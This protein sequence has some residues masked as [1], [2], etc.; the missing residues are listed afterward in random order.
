VN[1]AG[2]GPV[3]TVAFT[4]PAPPDTSPPVVTPSVSGAEG[5]AGWY[6]SDVVVNWLVTDAESAISSRTGCDTQTLTRDTAGTVLT[7]R[8]TNGAG[9]TT[10]RS[11]TVKRDATPPAL[12]PTV[13]P[14]VV[15][16]GGTAVADPAVQDAM[17]GV[18]TSHTAC[19]PV[20]TG[21]VGSFAVSCTATDI[22]G[23]TATAWTPFTVVNAFLGFQ[24]P[25]SKAIIL[26]PGATLPVK[27][28]VGD[29][30]GATRSTA[31]DVEVRLSTAPYAS[32]EVLAAM[33]CAYS[34]KV[35]AYQCD[36][37]TPTSLATRVA[38]YVTVLQR[39]PSASGAWYVVP[40]GRGVT[41]TNSAKVSFR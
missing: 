30:S 2:A 36:L 28:T 39:V 33:P 32:G 20:D 27:F 31:A 26:R 9:L 40:D 25:V 14:S 4:Q 35:S 6:V 10:T 13:S 1:L 23:N 12:S 11:I 3:V 29:V 5:D 19:A 38:F 24:A 22:A 15:A 37:K 7:C 18:D 41:S 34:R 16:Q 17:S 8:A 21:E